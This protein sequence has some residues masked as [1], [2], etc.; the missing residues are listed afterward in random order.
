VCVNVA[1]P[2]LLDYGRSSKY[3]IRA[4]ECGEAPLPLY[5][6][7]PRS[8]EK[9][10]DGR[11]SWGTCRDFI[12]N[13]SSI[14]FGCY[15]SV[16]YVAWILRANLFADDVDMSCSNE[17]TPFAYDLRVGLRRNLQSPTPKHET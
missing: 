4:C 17:V 9:A 5:K 7:R 10:H 16:V 13:F 2:E 3:I 15:D 8:S 14:A 1:T 6:F 12:T 11:T